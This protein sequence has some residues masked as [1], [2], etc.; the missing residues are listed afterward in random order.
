MHGERNETK[1]RRE[2]M[3]A[4]DGQTTKISYHPPTPSERV[5]WR[6]EILYSVRSTPYSGVS[7]ESPEYFVRSIDVSI[8]VLEVFKWSLGSLPWGRKVK[9]AEQNVLSS[10]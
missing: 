6:A 8:L 5:V 2:E 1:E 3:C 4:F 9:R 10:A 7:T